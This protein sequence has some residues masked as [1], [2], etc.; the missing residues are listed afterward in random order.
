[1]CLLNSEEVGQKG[2]LGSVMEGLVWCWHRSKI[3]RFP[4]T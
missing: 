3:R 1:M 4:K 2:I